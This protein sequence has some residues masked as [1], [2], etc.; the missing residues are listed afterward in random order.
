M[1]QLQATPHIQPWWVHPPVVSCFSW[2]PASSPATQPLP[3]AIAG[4]RFPGLREGGR[5]APRGPAGTCW[6]TP[7]CTPQATQPS[8]ATLCTVSSSPGPVAPART[9]RT[10]PSCGRAAQLKPGAG[11]VSRGGGPAQAASVLLQPEAAQLQYQPL[12]QR[13][14]AL[15][16]AAGA[17]SSVRPLG[18]R[19]Q[20]MAGERLAT[21]PVVS[22]YPRL[23]MCAT[24]LHHHAAPQH[25]SGPA[26]GTMRCRI[27]IEGRSRVDG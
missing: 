9:L 15:P 11:D 2:C 17:V 19:E 26:R 8:G 16:G 25:L 20:K 7:S 27:A 3:N 10:H 13:T 21:P 23:C 14:S 18:G 5:V 24:S 4:R 12:T 6:H 22:V 1:D